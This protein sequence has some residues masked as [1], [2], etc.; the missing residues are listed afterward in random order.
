VVVAVS[1]DGTRLLLGQAADSRPS[2]ELVLD[3]RVARAVRGQPLDDNTPVTTSALSPKEI[4]ARLRAGASVDDVAK[5]AGVPVSRVE[6]YAGPVLSE[7]E[8]VLD[9]IRS[10]TLTRARVG[11]SGKPLGEAVAT[12]LATTAFTRSGTAEWSAYRRI[13]GEWVA[14]LEVVVRGRTRRAE[15]LH[16]AVS[17]DA[18]ALDPYAATLGF[19]APSAP[20]VS[21]PNGGDAPTGEAAEPR[22]KATK[23]AASPAVQAPAAKKSV[24]KTAAAKTTAPKATAPKKAPTKATATKKSAAPPLANGAKRSDTAT[25]RATKAAGAA[26]AARRARPAS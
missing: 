15:W 3:E 2:H 23:S 4:Q 7:R 24:S 12:N 19:T 21:A 25:R 9:T 26:P 10:A 8:N 11:R 22:A 5:A 1:A 13:D 17:G 14:R 16:D 18:V 20:V 6:R